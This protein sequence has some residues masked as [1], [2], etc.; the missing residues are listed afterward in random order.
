MKF[1]VSFKETFNATALTALRRENW[2]GSRWG[3]SCRVEV[4]TGVGSH[5]KEYMCLKIESFVEE[6]LQR[7]SQ[8]IPLWQCKVEAPVDEWKDEGFQQECVR[9]C[10]LQVQE[11][12]VRSCRC[13]PLH[14]QVEIF[15]DQNI[16]KL[17]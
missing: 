16:E 8:Y 15:T 7:Y 9:S 13:C 1:K 10:L 2:M 11:P 3:K 5:L 4:L 6:I 14:L 17:F 12:R